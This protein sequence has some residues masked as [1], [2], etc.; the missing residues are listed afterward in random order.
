MSLCPCLCVSLSLC[1]SF[2]VCQCEPSTLRV[3]QRLKGLSPGPLPQSPDRGVRQVSASAPSSSLSRSLLTWGVGTDFSL[4]VQAQAWAGDTRDMQVLLGGRGKAGR[5][6][7]A[8][9]QVGN[10]SSALR[11]NPGPACSY[12]W[13]AGQLSWPFLG[14]EGDPSYALPQPGPGWS[15]LNPRPRPRWQRGR[16]RSGSPAQAQAQ[17]QDGPGPFP[18]ERPGAAGP[19]GLPLAT[20]PVHPRFMVARSTLRP[21]S[22]RA[23]PEAPASPAPPSFPTGVPVALGCFG[24]A[25]AL[26]EPL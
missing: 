12:L 13:L 9:Q 1:L 2:P 3:Q 4:G 24:P 6:D 7:E 8:P 19:A 5:V 16:G 21:S 25:L 18:P 17:R 14:L 11:G 10:R 26:S 22:S 15:H 20:G 23:A